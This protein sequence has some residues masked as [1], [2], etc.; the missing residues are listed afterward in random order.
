MK[1]SRRMM[2]V[3]LTGAASLLFLAPQA[4]AQGTLF[5]EGNK[6]GVGI[7]TPS[8]KFHLFGSDGATTFRVEETSATTSGRIMMHLINNG[9]VNFFME[10]TAGDNWQFIG[11]T[12]GSFTGF[13]ISRAGS[14]VR[15]FRVSPTGDVY[16]NGS[17]VHS[18]SRTVKEH[19]G[20]IDNLEIL[21]RLREV[22]VASWSYKHEQSNSARHLGPMAEDF[23]AAFGLGFDDK[24]IA[25]NDSVGVALAAIQGLHDLVERKDGEIAEL[26][27]RLA[28]IEELLAEH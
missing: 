27:A 28:A 23:Y 2:A 12:G 21:E 22:P 7:A 24:H 9:G 25:V 13:S 16:V 18:S 26:K 11:Q 19:I 6:V 5:V 15:E 3:F 10:D 8:D 14:G 4:Q 20:E 17:L 1:H